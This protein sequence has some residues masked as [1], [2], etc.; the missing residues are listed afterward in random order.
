M[1]EQN[2]AD[3]SQQDPAAPALTALKTLEEYDKEIRAKGGAAAVAN[4]IAG[5]NLD[6]TTGL[7]VNLGKDKDQEEFG[8]LLM[9][10]YLVNKEQGGV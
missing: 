1:D 3:G 4:T 9:Q 10:R 6:G 7:P 5:W 8:L 2:A